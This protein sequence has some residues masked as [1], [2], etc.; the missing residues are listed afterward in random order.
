MNL[1]RTFTAGDGSDSTATVI[2]YLKAGRQFELADLVLIGEVT[3]SDAVWLT[4]W[5]AP[6]VYSQW[7]TFNPANFERGKVESKVGLEVGTLDFKWRPQ[8]SS[9]LQNIAN[10]SPYQLAQ[11][12]KFDNRKFRLWRCVMPTPGDAN[13]YGACEYF[14][15]RIAKSIVQSGEIYFTVNSFLD[16][17]NQKVPIATITSTSILPNFTGATPVLADGET[18][19]PIFSCEPGSSQ[20]VILA[21]CLSPTAN[22]IYAINKFKNGYLYFQPNSTLAGVWSAIGTSQPY[23]YAPGPKRWNQFFIYSPLPW[24]PTP[25]DQFYVSTQKPPTQPEGSFLYVP[26][27]EQ[28]F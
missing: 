2:A 13:T 16:V 8:A 5:N 15:G 25:G 4:S 22:K 24:P 20:T 17:L 12:G 6:L 7:G 27:P 23:N 28:A 3:D 14:G 18:Q 11:I 9:F 1:T 10:A 19:I 26:A 21:A